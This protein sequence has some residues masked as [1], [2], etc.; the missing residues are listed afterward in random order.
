MNYADLT[1]PQVAALPANTVLLLPVGAVEPHGP[2]AP[3]CTDPLI[4]LGICRRVVRQL[5][6]DPE[7][8]A[9][10]LPPLPYGV[11]RFARGFPGGIHISA[12]TL[13]ALITDI[14]TALIGQGHRYLM[15]VNNHFEPEHVLTLHR[16]CDTVAA[17]TGVVAGFLDL[18][19]RH[20]A[21]ALTEEFRKGECHAGR[22]ETSLVLAEAPDLIDRAAMAG[23]PHV[24]ISLIT[25]GVTGFA[26]CGM[27]QAYNGAPAAASAAEGK[28]TFAI[29]TDMLIA[30]MR[31]LVRGTGGRD[32]PR[33]GACP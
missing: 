6:G 19:R 7:L 3:L 23:L 33:G 31:E 10:I 22:Y 26:A 13:H 28:A 5:Q 27:D 20:R 16:A 14:C 9:L 24:P 11:T 30:Q 25:P 32:R 2:H 29:L 15:L 1:F 17:Q 18:T 12:E 4:S 8:G 21:E